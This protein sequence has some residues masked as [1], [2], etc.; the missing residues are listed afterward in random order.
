MA[1]NNALGVSLSWSSSS[2]RV[3]EKYQKNYTLLWF[4]SRRSR[5]ENVF[6]KGW[7]FLFLMLMQPITWHPAG[8]NRVQGSVLL[9]IYVHIFILQ[10]KR[11]MFI[12]LLI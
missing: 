9:L 8:V 4:S 6:S 2:K 5:M 1:I 12:E 7:L 11:L 10:E 3:H